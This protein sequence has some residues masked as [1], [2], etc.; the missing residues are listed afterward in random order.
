MSGSLGESDTEGAVI[1]SFNGA[2][3]VLTI[4]P[5]NV[6]YLRQ[7]KWTWFLVYLKADE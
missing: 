6:E 7:G 4:D 5:Q 2:M 1:S 3:G